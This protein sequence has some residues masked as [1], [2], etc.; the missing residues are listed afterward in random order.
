MNHV[1][2]SYKH[3]VASQRYL[4]LAHSFHFYSTSTE[5]LLKAQHSVNILFLYSLYGKL[6][7]GASCILNFFLKRRI[8][9][10]KEFYR[11]LSFPRIRKVVDHCAS[12]SYVYEFVKTFFTVVDKIDYKGASKIHKTFSSYYA[13]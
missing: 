13:A 5:L 9:C 1:S 11:G 12:L 10:T 8:C 4:A 3:D 6:R 2:F 7:L